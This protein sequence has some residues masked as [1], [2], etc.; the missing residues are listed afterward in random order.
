MGLWQ[1]R[2]FV[3]RRTSRGGVLHKGRGRAHSKALRGKFLQRQTLITASRLV[4]LSNSCTEFQLPSYMKSFQTLI[5][6]PGTG[7]RK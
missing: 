7:I 3:I 6:N 1:L 5:R 2:T 4:D